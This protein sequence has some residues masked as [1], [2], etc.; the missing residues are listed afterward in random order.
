MLKLEAI[1][2]PSREELYLD[3]P[4][5]VYNPRVFELFELPSPQDVY[6]WDRPPETTIHYRML[7]TLA[8]ALKREPGQFRVVF[9]T[10]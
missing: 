9:W 7:K 5:E 1:K 3:D 10:D 2:D 4:E 8:Q 6:E